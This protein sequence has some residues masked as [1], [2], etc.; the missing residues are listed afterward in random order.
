MNNAEIKPAFAES[1]EVLPIDYALAYSILSRRMAAIAALLS[2]DQ[3]PEHCLKKV[4]AQ[5][6]AAMETI[7]QVETVRFVVKF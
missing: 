5:V 7:E 2:A 1:F 4:K 6:D 3:W